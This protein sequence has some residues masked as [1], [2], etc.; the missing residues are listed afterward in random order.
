[1]K[2]RERETRNNMRH[3]GDQ[4]IIKEGQIASAPVKEIIRE[5]D[6]EE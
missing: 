3:Y 4:V 5:I 2:S 6:A 1:M